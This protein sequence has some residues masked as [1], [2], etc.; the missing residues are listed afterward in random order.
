MLNIIIK[1]LNNARLARDCR[2]DS[3][4]IGVGSFAVNFIYRVVVLNLFIYGSDAAV[5]IDDV[6]GIG[7]ESAFLRRLGLSYIKAM[8]VSGF[9]TPFVTYTPPS[10]ITATLPK[11]IKIFISG[12]M[13][14]IIMPA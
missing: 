6:V 2:G 7:D 5:K 9:E 4:I 1:V 13:L 10:T 8:I 14:L 3:D 12:F 11:F